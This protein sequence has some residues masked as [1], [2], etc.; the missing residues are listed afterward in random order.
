MST[1]DY[2]T[3]LDTLP[4]DNAR[5]SSGQKMPAT[6]NTE[7]YR[8]D[9]DA[10][11]GKD[12]IAGYRKP[13]R[14][15]RSQQ[16]IWTV[17]AVFV[18]TMALSF[19]MGRGTHRR[20]RH[21]TQAHKHQNFHRP[22]AKD[23]EL[24][25]PLLYPDLQTGPDST[26]GQAWEALSRV[27]CHEKIFDRSRDNGTFRLMGPDIAHFAPLMCD[28]GCRT[29]ILHASEQISGA[30]S[31]E[32]TFML[33]DYA[34]MFNASL[35]ESGPVAALDTLS[36]RLQHT[37][38]K[39]PADDS[40][41]DFCPIELDQ[42]FSI[43]DGMNVPYLDDVLDDLA[44]F[45]QHTDR[46]RLEQAQRKTGWRG[47]NKY[48]ERYDYHTREQKYGPGVGETTCRWCTLDWL[49]RKLGAWREGSIL[50]PDSKVPVS[51]PE[52]L[53]RI[54]K[55][56][57]RC[58]PE[59]WND[60]FERAVAR[61]QDDG[62]LADNW[63]RLPSGDV[64]YLI[65]N[66]ADE[67]DEP[68]PSFAKAIERIE[69][70]ATSPGS[71]HNTTASGCLRAMTALIQSMPCYIH[72]DRPTLETIIR[73]PEDRPNLRK[74]YCSAECTDA[75]N[76]GLP[77][78]C[79]IPFTQN[80]AA[81]PAFVDAFNNAT[82][83]RNKICVSPSG[84]SSPKDVGACS[85]TFLQLDH[86]DWVFDGRPSSPQFVDQV[87]KK[88]NELNSLAIPE[89]IK[90]TLDSPHPWSAPIDFG[91]R[92]TYY[93]WV[94]DLRKGVCSPC[95]WQWLVGSGDTETPLQYLREMD[96]IDVNTYTTFAQTYYDTCTALGAD[97]LGGIPYGDDPAIW[98]V[99]EK[100]SVYRYK[101]STDVWSSRGQTTWNRVEE[102][103]G[104]VSMPREHV[105]SLWH[106]FKARREA[107]AL[108]E[109]RWEEWA[110]EEEARVEAADAEIWKVTW[111]G[112]VVYLSEKQKE[113]DR[114]D[115]AAE[116]LRLEKARRK[117]VDGR[118]T[119]IPAPG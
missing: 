30:C 13:A 31:A 93:T 102:S 20:D 95:I 41:Y 69:D 98:R 19:L 51:L 14:V 78:Q 105:G 89:D 116:S 66:G 44:S 77:Y 81:V 2:D 10:I 108:R 87:S 49:E 24:N 35:L 109:G 76:E 114:E 73:E 58:E 82:E 92:R 43:I 119:P 18:A 45:M 1:Q 48:K 27:P 37:C 11:P 90:P 57:M 15:T 56:G 28:T 113:I 70:V 94:A 72:L 112:S 25:F 47:T 32:D 50:S 83:K 75:L 12:E 110:K 3:R 53:R 17:L 99:Q 59:A 54:E 97:W 60:M 33:E 104:Q 100:G 5:D 85:N 96:D 80:N 91:P 88:L 86:P 40:D 106:L 7:R 111:S 23:W 65:K 39:S 42:R 29:A 46:P 79:R 61:Y 84:S 26:C 68:L 63:R 16:V 67:G 21:R 115:A 118:G 103:T 107:D 38:R 4:G 34:G 6:S 71:G 36:R 52:F 64:Y 62:L 9:P 101:A 117:T 8:D 22:A 74:S 55:A